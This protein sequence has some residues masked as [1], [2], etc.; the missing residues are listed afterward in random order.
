MGRLYEAGFVAATV[1]S[2]SKPSSFICPRMTEE[3]IGGP[4][5]ALA[6]L[7]TAG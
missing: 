3:S 7:A 6:A 1:T 2:R 5:K 4:L